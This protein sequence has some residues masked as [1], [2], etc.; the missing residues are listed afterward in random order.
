MTGW[1]LKTGAGGP[2]KVFTPFWKRLA[3]S[4]RDPAS[5]PA[6]KRLAAPV[7]WPGSEAAEGWQVTARWSEAFG[8]TW[9][10]GEA[11]AHARLQDFINRA[12][13]YPDARDR[14]D[15]E[16]TSRFSPH[17][18][19]GEISV[20]EIWRRLSAALGEDAL[21]FLRQLGWKP[22]ELIAS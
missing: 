4:Y 19:W 14:P 16:G 10:P 5:L 18:A 8:A 9:S 7:A 13:D 22:L 1:R 17:L 21:P 20:H 6:P 2:F 11:G 3:E 15:R 12:A